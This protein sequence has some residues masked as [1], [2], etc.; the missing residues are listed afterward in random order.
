MPANR[1]P[2]F[3]FIALIAMNFA[4]VAFSIDAMMP[5]LPEI[6]HALIPSD[7][8]R[9]QLVITS[10]VFGM[11]VGTFFAGPLSDR[12][13]RKP[14]IAAGAV[15]Y[16]IGAAWAAKASSLEGLVAARILQGLGVAGPRVVAIAIVRDLYEGRQMARI[17]SYAMMIFT[18]VPAIAPLI[19]SFIIANS[20]WRMIFI[21]CIA[22]CAISVGWLLLRQPET[23]AR[24]NC[25]P[26]R[27]QTILAAIR[28]CF[29]HREF[30]ISV[31][32]QSLALGVLFACL[33]SIHSIFEQTWDRA[34]NF[35]LWFALIAIVSAS[36][37]VLNAWLVVRLGMR[38]MISTGFLMQVVISGLVTALLLLGMLNFATYVLWTASIFF[39]VGLVLGNLNALAMEP[40]G[41]I[42]GL[43][44]S[45]LGALSTVCSVAIAVP[46]GLA[47]DGTPLP[48]AAATFVLSVI[49]YL[50]VK[51][52]MR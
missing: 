43:S 16:V 31:L 23:L 18:L 40:L 15:L 22:F 4:M 14:V 38:R 47:F 10:F 19:G 24:E 25:R 35:P 52:A 50:L 41:H 17:M 12:F 28:E 32:A 48:L 8:N 9:A 27:V 26:F 44:A 34:E 37:S 39:M 6:G 46:V 11:G 1:L 30:L 33:S 42:A 7:I 13:Q 3:E 51:F 29:A 20:S 2:Q 49:S 21:A 45:I 36:A 5:A